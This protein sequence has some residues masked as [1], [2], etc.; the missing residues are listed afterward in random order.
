MI[1]TSDNVACDKLLALVGGPGVVDAR[2]RALGIDHVDD[3]LHGARSRRTGKG[4]N[5]ATP[6]AMVALLAKIA[7]HEVG[8]SPRARRCWRTSSCG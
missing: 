6:A 3:P 8:L 7:R 4:D 1:I 5:T 2:V